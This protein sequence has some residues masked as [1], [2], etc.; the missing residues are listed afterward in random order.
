MYANSAAVVA[1]YET[2]QK[3][4]KRIIAGDSRRRVVVV[5]APGKRSPDDRKVTD[6]LIELAKTKDDA[7]VRAITEK[8]MCVCPE[9]D[10]KSVEDLICQRI[11]Q[12]LPDN[13]Y[14]DSMKALGEEACARF[15]APFF[16]AEFVDVRELLRLTPDF[17]D[18]KILP[19]SQELIRKRLS[20]NGLYIVP[21]F[22]GMTADGRVAT[23]SRGGSDTTGAWVAAALDA[24]LYENYTD[25]NGVRAAS[26]EIVPDA[27]KIDE[28][29]F[30]ELRDLSYSGFNVFHPE[31][32]APVARKGIP[33]HIRSTKDYPKNGTCVVADRA[34][35]PLRPIVGVAYQNGFCAFNI[36]KYGLNE[37]VGIE[38]DILGIF[39]ARGM[40]V[41]HTPS[42]ID[43]F[44]VVLKRGQLKEAG[45]VNHLRNDILSV[46]GEGA[47][48]DFIDDLGIVVVA[49][50]D[51]R[52]RRGISAD[53]ERT[54]ADADVNI[55][56]T[57][58]GVR[59]RCMIIGVA[60]RDGKKAV[61][62]IYDRF[63]R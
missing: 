4:K 56:F 15:L 18:A 52:G 13:E 34:G 63:L 33:I 3:I 35:D 11:K 9:G 40:S 48:A 54:V 20:G 41:E 37:T 24:I 47:S 32:V 60:D 16:G 21:G 58:Q 55:I 2:V 36:E 6:M 19:E 57:S 61:N 31:A 49:G 1:K 51:L 26:F 38:H 5:S 30:R 39:K 59:E 62:A 42:G 50:K 27:K 17:G 14:L 29:T 12:N 23:L 44:S 43:D 25:I 10:V 53:V 28:L 46:A 22:Y 8:Y 45:Q 7:L